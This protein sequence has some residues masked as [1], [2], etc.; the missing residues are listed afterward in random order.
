MSKLLVYRSLRSYSSGPI[1]D[2][3]Q[4]AAAEAV[5]KCGSVSS[6]RLSICL[7]ASL[8]DQPVDP[9]RPIGFLYCH[10]N[11]SSVS[12]PADPPMAITTSADIGI[13]A[14]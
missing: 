3:A 14:F 9:S 1:V 11:D 7:P 6:L 4:C 12:V 5:G 8:F 2:S 13:I 10:A